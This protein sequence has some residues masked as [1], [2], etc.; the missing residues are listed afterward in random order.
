MRERK[1]RMGENRGRREK[2]GKRGRKRDE[3]EEREEG[4]RR[5][6]SQGDQLA[7]M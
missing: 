6:L 5:G 3:G 4:D 2:R 1:G 7:K